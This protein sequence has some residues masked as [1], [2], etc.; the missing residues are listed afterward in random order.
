[1]SPK[2]LVTILVSMNAGGLGKHKSWI[3]TGLNQLQPSTSLYRLVFCYI[4]T[5][6]MS[7][8]L[9][10]F[11]LFTNVCC[12]AGHVTGPILFLLL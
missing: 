2:H 8:T 4:Y 7:R 5:R 3:E 1:M 6:P 10:N 11:F 9:L 12:T